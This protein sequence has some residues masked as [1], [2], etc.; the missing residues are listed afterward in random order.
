MHGN[1]LTGL[2]HKEGSLRKEGSLPPSKQKSG[3]LGTDSSQMLQEVHGAASAPHPIH[4]VPAPAATI[5]AEP[6]EKAVSL[7][8]WNHRGFLPAAAQVPPATV[9]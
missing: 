5:R 8:T 7:F 3:A 2:C 1:V 9:S 4:H 6:R